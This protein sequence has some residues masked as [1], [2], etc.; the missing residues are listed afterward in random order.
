MV[1]VFYTQVTELLRLY[2]KGVLMVVVHSDGSSPGRAGFKMFVTQEEMFGSI[3]GGI[4]EHKW[5]EFCHEIL[6]SEE[7]TPIL[8]RQIHQAD[9]GSDR[10]GM[11]CSGEQSIAFY[12]LNEKD[13]KRLSDVFNEGAG[14]LIYNSQ[15]IYF[16]VKDEMLNFLKSEDIHLWRYIEPVK[17]SHHIYIVGGGHVAL[18]LS[19]VMS[20]L[21]F[22]IHVFDDRPGLNTMAV[23]SFAHFK[24]VLSYDE[25]EQWIPEGLNHY[26]VIVTFGYRSDKQ[27][28]LKLAGREY[29]YIGMMGSKAKM[30]T[31][32]KE[33]L[34]EGVL[35]EWLERLMAP[36]GISIKSKTPFEIA[37]SIAAELIAFK[38]A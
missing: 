11:I 1:L 21:N 3:G 19:E 14:F 38:N 5:V 25:I 32:R 6:D 35:Q 13:L 27:I 17:F 18:A 34:N 4:M 24:T 26:V 7:F 9:I 8:K 30:E 33:L 12:L 36:A 22:C 23:N 29:R 20:K 15:G 10:S 16:S 28:A 37:I 31:L 2:R